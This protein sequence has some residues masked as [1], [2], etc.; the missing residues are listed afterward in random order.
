MEGNTFKIGFKIAKGR[1]LS[2]NGGGKQTERT[3]QRGTKNLKDMAE[4]I[5][6]SENVYIKAYQYCHSF[7]FLF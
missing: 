5:C 6:S 7:A 2:S 3:E 4:R 1:V